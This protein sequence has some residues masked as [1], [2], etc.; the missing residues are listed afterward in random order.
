M[1]THN[2]NELQKHFPKLKKQE[3]EDCDCMI[4]FVWKMRKDKISGGGNQIHSC[5]RTGNGEEGEGI[6]CTVVGGTF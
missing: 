3:T 4:P 6:D 1:D 2:I 5:Q